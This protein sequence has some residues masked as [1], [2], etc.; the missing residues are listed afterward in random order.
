VAGII[1]A[2]G[3]NGIGVTGVA[4][5]A[6]I[7]PVK[8]LDKKGSGADATVAR[9]VCFAVARSARIINLSLGEDPLSQLLVDGTG[10]QTA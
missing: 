1:A 10:R 5:N 7:L 4:P 2:R 8:V 9:G 6:R 3:G